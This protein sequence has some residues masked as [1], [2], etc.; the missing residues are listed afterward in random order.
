MTRELSEFFEQSDVEIAPDDGRRDE[1]SLR[2]LAESL[3]A[4]AD[5][6][7]HA[8]REL[9]VLFREAGLCPARSAEHAFGLRHVQG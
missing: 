4:A 2:G 5:Q 3:E 9:Q 6:A 8:L 1:H 7:A